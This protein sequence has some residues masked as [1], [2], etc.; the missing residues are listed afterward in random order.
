MTEEQV[1]NELRR[2]AQ[3]ISAEPDQLPT[4]C[5]LQ[6]G[7]RANI[8]ISD[9]GALSYEAYERGIQTFCFTFTGLDDLMYHAFKE[10]VAQIA[11]Q[12]ATKMEANGM[13]FRSHFFKKKI[14]LMGLVDARWAKRLEEET[15]EGF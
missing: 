4:V 13:D 5:R 7:G 2:I 15:R 3:L 10:I 12:Y 11:N 9:N 14:A 1:L 8:E 6:G